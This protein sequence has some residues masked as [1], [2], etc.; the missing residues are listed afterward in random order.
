[1]VLGFA[2][3]LD[4]ATFQKKIQFEFVQKHSAQNFSCRAS[5]SG[6]LAAP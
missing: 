3:I 5:L 4:T 1:M 2:V 6:R